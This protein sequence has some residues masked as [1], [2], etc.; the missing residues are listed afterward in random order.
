MFRAKSGKQTWEK[1]ANEQFLTEQMRSSRLND[2][3]LKFQEKIHQKVCISFKMLEK[4]DDIENE[5]NTN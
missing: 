2:L 1:N 3:K 5:N 4:L